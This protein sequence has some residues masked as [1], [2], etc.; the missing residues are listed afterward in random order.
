VVNGNASS[1]KEG[2]GKASKKQRREK[3][4]KEGSGRAEQVSLNR[5]ALM[6]R[7]RRDQALAKKK[8]MREVFPCILDLMICGTDRTRHSD[9][10]GGTKSVCDDERVKAGYRKCHR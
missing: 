7:Q 1:G 10:R 6:V 5:V 4:R 8:N 9:V 3:R 2:G